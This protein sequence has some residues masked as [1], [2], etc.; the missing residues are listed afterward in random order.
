VT[1]KL[2]L[3]VAAFDIA[4]ATG[5][6][7]GRVSEKPKVMTWDLRAVGPNRSRRLLHFSDLCDEFFSR[8]QIDVLRY[9][10]PLSITVASRIGASED[11]ML[12]LR[13]MIGVLECCAARA[14]I[15]NINSFG[16]QDAREHLTGQRTFPKNA[17][18]KSEAK[19]AVMKV[20]KMLGIECADDNQADAY[21]GWS[22]TCSLLNPRLAH[23]VTPLFAGKC[24]IVRR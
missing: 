5:I 8:H 20:A 12:L 23:L 18:G 16:V 6:C 3:L 21:A 14:H 10:A 2:P 4:T 15:F 22:Y 1:E 7:L 17:K 13:G 19:A 11:T 9:E 24:H